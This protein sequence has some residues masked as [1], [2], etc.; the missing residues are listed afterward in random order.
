MV[1]CR[2]DNFPL[3]LD[4]SGCAAIFFRM[5]FNLHLYGWALCAAAAAAG[6]GVGEESRSCTQLMNGKTVLI[7]DGA[8]VTSISD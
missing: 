3:V 1:S 6:S 5:K 4:H 2:M 8:I 7:A